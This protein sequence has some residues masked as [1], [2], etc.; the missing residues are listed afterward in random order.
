MRKIV[1][2]FGLISGGIMAV[3]M[4][5]ATIF[6]DQIGFDRGFL[7]GYT[8]MVAAFLMVFFGVRAYRDQV[9]GG[10]I[11]FGRAMGVGSLITLIGTLC[12]V[13]TWEVIYFK[14]TPEFMDRYVA[15]SIEKAKAA[16]VPD[17]QLAKQ[18][19][20]LEQF[21]VQ[22]KNPIVNAAYTFIEPLPVG[23]LM[24]LIA[25]GVLRRRRRPGESPDAVTA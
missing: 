10:S 5:I 12:Y 9:G 20:E 3:M 7:V 16:G 21:K 4:V 23:V 24:T 25:A 15:Y 22:Y 2:T 6:Q 19:E 1:L 14:F 13:A 11:S 17:A 18:R 8:S